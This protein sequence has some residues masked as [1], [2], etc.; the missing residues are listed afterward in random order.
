MKKGSLYNFMN[1]NDFTKAMKHA[2]TKINPL[3]R[4]KVIQ[5]SLKK[6]PENINERFLLNF[7]SMIEKFSKMNQQI[8]K[9][10]RGRSVD[11]KQILEIQKYISNID[12][13]E[14]NSSYFNEKGALNLIIVMEEFNEITEEIAKFIQG[15]G[16]HDD[17]LEELSDAMLSIR[18]VQLICGIS[19]EELNK[20]MNVKLDR[21][22]KR[23]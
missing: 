11:M 22:N 9:F 7:V 6:I 23:N 18:Y 20:A 1:K 16:K 4:D 12:N 8:S 21:Q 19:D 10:I 14:Q 5:E 3:Y 2:D 17:I 13:K 15:K